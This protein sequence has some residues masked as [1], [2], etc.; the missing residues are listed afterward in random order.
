MMK[1]H[2]EYQSPK[3]PIHGRPIE[4]EKPG[5]IYINEF[6]KIIFMLMIQIY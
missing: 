2:M 1:I 3:V 4:L 6:S 5:Y